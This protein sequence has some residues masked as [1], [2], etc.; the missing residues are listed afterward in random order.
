MD[1]AALVPGRYI[2]AA[3]LGVALPRNP[4]FTIVSARLEEMASL[5]PGAAEK[6]EDK[7]VIS[8]KEIKRG[9]V[10]NK[11][12]VACL[13]ALFGSETN[14]WE[15]KRVTLCTQ[16]TNT[17]PGIR[18]LGSPDITA[19]VEVTIKMPRKRPVKMMMQPT[20]GQIVTPTS[21]FKRAL[22]AAVKEGRWAQEQITELLLS[23][24]KSDDVPVEEYE[25]I[26]AKLALGP[27]AAAKADE[28]VAPV[29]DIGEKL[30]F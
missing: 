23:G 6:V 18:V 24:R 28:T 11:T 25:E 19:P 5:K 10:M 2:G 29:E 1:A 16:P 26:T 3:D 17:G 7:G 30:D 13:K 21:L 4:T 12:N 20:A 22:G 27:E 9:W 8:F 14:G 15:G